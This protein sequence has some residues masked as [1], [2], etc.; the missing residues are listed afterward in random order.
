[1][2]PKSLTQ[3]IKTVSIWKRGDKRAPHKP[4]LLLLALARV[5]RG[6][7]RLTPFEVL[8]SEL[9]DLLI[10]FGPQ[11][12]SYH[13]EYPFWRLQNDGNFWEIPE[14]EKAI[15]ARGTRVRKGDVPKNVLVEVK[16]NAGFCLE[17]HQVLQQNQGLLFQIATYLLEEQFPP[18]MHEDIFAAIG[19]PRAYKRL[20]DLINNDF[21]STML[22]IYERRCCVCGFDGKLGNATVGLEAAHVKW[23]KAEGPDAPENGLLLCNFHHK[24]F[25]RGVMGITLGHQITVS[26]HLHGGERVKELILQFS[27]KRYHPPQ[28]GFPRI[29][30]EYI[31]WHSEEVFR[32]PARHF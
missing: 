10:N 7:Q 16:A 30:E 18:S 27:G 12:K 23:R 14:R 24:M 6:E 8:Y 17:A 22:R 32:F 4:L 5:A 28:N 19:M 31:K 29:A 13:P 3:Q 9:E 20:G 21:R 26:Q 11:R 25:D 15:A 2:N 1:M